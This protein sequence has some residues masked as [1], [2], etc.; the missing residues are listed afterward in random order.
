MQ[1]YLKQR[2]WDAERQYI[3]KRRSAA[4]LPQSSADAGKV[5][6][7]PWSLSSPLCAF[8]GMFIFTNC[9]SNHSFINSFM[10]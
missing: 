1:R 4:I 5:R 9:V 7:S 8:Y 10:G 6:I 2:A 3:Q